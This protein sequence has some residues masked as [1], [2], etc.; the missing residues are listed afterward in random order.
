M[1]EVTGLD[2]WRKVKDET[3]GTFWVGN[4]FDPSA[5]VSQ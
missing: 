2:G 4:Q 3:F 5:G 1:E